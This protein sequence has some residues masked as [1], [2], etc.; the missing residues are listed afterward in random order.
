MNWEE[1]GADENGV[2]TPLP[3]LAEGQSLL[4]F[5]AMVVS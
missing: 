3:E 1:P 5:H 4:W 2:F